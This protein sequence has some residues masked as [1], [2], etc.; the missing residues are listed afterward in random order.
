MSDKKRSTRRPPNNLVALMRARNREPLPDFRREVLGELVVDHRAPYG[1]ASPLLH[2]YLRASV[3]ITD[4]MTFTPSAPPNHF[5]LISP[6]LASEL[7]PT[8]VVLFDRDLAHR[9]TNPVFITRWGH[10]YVA[11]LDSH[12][13]CWCWDVDRLPGDERWD[14]L[15]GGIWA[16]QYEPSWMNCL[17]RAR[18]YRARTQ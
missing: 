16:E 7:E 3:N 2:H 14:D 5:L 10:L 8:A 6:A 18:A 4:A 1:S 17:D 9:I 13:V 12:H 15:S 11:S